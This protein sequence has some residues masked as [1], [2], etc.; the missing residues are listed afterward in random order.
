MAIPIDQYLHQEVKDYIRDNYDS[1]KKVISYFR[2][3]SWQSSRYIQVSTCLKDS[4]IHYEYYNGE[5]QLH[6]EGKYA[7]GGYNDFKGFLAECT[8][9]IPN[10]KWKRW[11]GRNKGSCVLERNIDSTDDLFQAFSDMIK[12]FDPLIKEF[13]DKNEDIFSSPYKTEPVIDRSYTL[14]ED[15]PEQLPHVEICSVGSLPFDNFVI[16]PY[17]RPYKWTAKNVNQLISDILAFRERKQYRLGTLVLHNNEIVDGQQRIITIA[18][19]IRVMYNTL[20]DE[21]VKANY[22][23]I[24]KKINAFSNSDKVSFSNRYTLH[25]VI[26][27]INTIESRKLDFDQQLFDF[28]LTKCEF[29]VV[30]LNNISEAFQFFDSQ[31]AR[32][33]DLAAH[34]LLKAYHLREI[35]TLNQEDSRNIDEWQK[36]PTS[37]LNEVFLTLFRAKRWSRGKWGRRFTKDHTDIFKGI[38]LSDGKRYPFYQKEVIAHI[39]SS[40]YNQDPI[41]AIDRNHMEYPFNL[42][43]QII[44]GGRFFDMIRHY[45][46]LYEYIRNYRQSLPDGSRAKEILNLITS[47]NGSGRTGDGYIRDMF[48]TLLLYYVDRFGEEEL[49]KIIPQFFIWAYK[50][51]LQ[52]SAVQLASIDNYATAWDSMFRHVYDAKTPYDIIN[53]NIEGVQLKQ[54][55]GCEQI[56]NLFKEYNKYYGND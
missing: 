18:L 53:I 21:K 8:S 6:F 44:N 56:K 4:D 55:S 3:G 38:S 7:E 16:P 39:F 1:K 14:Q 40:L 22:H 19:L 17:Q 42:D 50:L 29:V 15:V 47:Y 28:L 41:R 5:V 23:E 49:D 36:K 26:E 11:Q 51:R 32:G 30:R 35:S 48:Y 33:K 10:L 27:N 52:M 31:N 46:N 25:N 37:F 9:D 43:D 2:E 45:M 24:D 54:C 13:A 12:I 20:K 34:D